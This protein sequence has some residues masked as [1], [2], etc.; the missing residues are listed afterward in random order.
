MSIIDHL[1]S[2]LGPITSGYKSSSGPEGV[3]VVC[4]RDQ[5]LRGTDTLV[6]LGLSHHVLNLSTKTV[7]QELLLSFYGSRT[8]ED[9]A[10]LL[11]HISEIILRNHRGL[12]RG[13]TLSL[14]Y[15]S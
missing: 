7:R 11:L 4:F 1:E 13:E 10:M 14:D 3:Q 6:T 8:T 2:Y 5:P 15:P 9:L 12:L